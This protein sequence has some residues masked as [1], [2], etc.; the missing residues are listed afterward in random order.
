MRFACDL[1]RGDERHAIKDFPFPQLLSEPRN[2]PEIK[3][4]RIKRKVPYYIIEILFKR[5]VNF[6][7]RFRLNFIIE[8]SKYSQKPDFLENQKCAPFLFQL[9]LKYSIFGILY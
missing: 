6:H 5:T 7:L 3:S 4:L 9:T 2:T 8:C 1:G